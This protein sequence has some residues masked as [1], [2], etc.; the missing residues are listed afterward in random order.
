MVVVLKW[1]LM[2][3]HFEVSFDD[4][5]FYELCDGGN[6]GTVHRALWISRGQ[7]VAVKK[8]LVLDNEVRQ[9]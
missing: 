7:E 3:G 4:L 6:Y 5:K 8:V 9:S 1:P 2:A